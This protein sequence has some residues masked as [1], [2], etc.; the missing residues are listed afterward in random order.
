MVHPTAAERDAFLW[1]QARMVELLLR[2]DAQRFSVTFREQI[3]DQADPLKDTFLRH[4]RDLAVLFYLRDELFE[5]I[6]PR[7]KRRLSFAAPRE[8]TVERLPPR[9][10]VDWGHTATTTL[11]TYPGE[12]P[13][14]VQTRQRRRHFATPENLLTVATLL[15]YRKSVQRLLDEEDR[16]DHILA[17]R[18]PLHG[19]VESCTR[20]LAFLQFAGLVREAQA[21]VEGFAKTSIDDLE[22]TVADHLLPG[23]NSA[24]DDLLDWRRRLRSLELLDRTA[25][26]ATT[27]LGANPDR[28]NYLYQLWLFYEIADLLRRTHRLQEWNINRMQ[29]TFRWG[30][31]DSAVDY[32]LTHDQAIVQHWHNAPG[33]RPDLYVRQNNAIEIRDGNDLI[34]REMGYVLDAKYYRPDE[35]GAMPASPIKRMIADLHLTGQQHGALLF[36]FHQGPELSDEA[37]L[38]KV[39]VMPDTHGIHAMLPETHIDIWCFQPESTVSTQ[40]LAT[41]LTTLLETIH[42][43]LKDPVPIICHGFLPDVDTINPSSTPLERCTQCNELLAYCPKPHVRHGH[44]DRVCPRCDCLRTKRMCHIIGQGTITA[45]P[46]VKR[47]LTQDDLFTNIGKLRTWLQEM[48]QADDESDEAEQQRQ[49][50]LRTIGEL[51]ESYIKLTRA[52]TTQTEQTL[53]EW[54]FGTYW[55]MTKTPRGLS[56]LARQML[57]SGEYVW[58]QFQQS[59]VEDWAACAVQYTRTLEHELHRRLYDPCGRHLRNRYGKPMRSKDFTIGTPGNAYDYRHDNHNWQTL[60]DYAAKPSGIDEATLVQLVADIESV[61]PMRNKVAHTDHVDTHLARELRETLL[62]AHGKQGLLLRL[63][64]VL[65]PG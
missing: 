9:G 65:D 62:G 14:E 58:N 22:A 10:R 18:H 20:E 6:L 38:F 53:R 23:R 36:A 54:V 49:Y 25:T 35:N 57:I 28:D 13:L 1:M 44:I 42:T 3:A 46:F 21:L 40:Q 39:Q 34:W 37:H 30:D 41:Q 16:Y 45:P 51:T 8:H 15:A 33:V 61:R 19:I 27:M 47:V 50:V 17:L 4:Y 11:H 60:L 59:T 24:Y 31:A 43:T 63:I 7:I 29:L 32:T 12:M 55:D 5:S 48:V 64:S 26:D 56:Q 2:Y 52:D